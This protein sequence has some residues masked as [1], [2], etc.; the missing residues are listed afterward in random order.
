M[1]LY[2]N[3]RIVGILI[4]PVL[5]FNA[6][7]H[8]LLK[9]GKLKKEAVQVGPLQFNTVAKNPMV[10]KDMTITLTTFMEMCTLL[11]VK[12]IVH[13]SYNTTLFGFMII[14]IVFCLLTPLIY[15]FSNQKLRK[16]AFRE[17]WDEAPIWMIQL[18]ENIDSRRNQND[19]VIEMQTI[20]DND[21]NQ[22][23][24]QNLE[25]CQPRA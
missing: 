22:T 5:F 20:G 10:M 4:F 1:K 12:N 13:G 2:L 21:D 17:F 6:F 18:K 9:I 24:L 16:Y 25:T 8:V 15:W 23:S 14:S 11:I 19:Q 7:L 3:F